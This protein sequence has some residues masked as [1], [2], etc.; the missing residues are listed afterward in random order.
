MSDLVH[1]KLLTD[2]E[3]REKCAEMRDSGKDIPQEYALALLDRFEDAL[4]DRDKMESDCDAANDLRKDAEEDLREMGDAI[5]EVK[6]ELCKLSD[7]IDSAGR[8][9]QNLIDM[10]KEL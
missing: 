5:T 8:K 1:E 2:D 7:D 4:R 9:L 3:L 6:E 10:V